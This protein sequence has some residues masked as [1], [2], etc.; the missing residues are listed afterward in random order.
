[1][2]ID[3]Q[4]VVRE[5]ME[6]VRFP[7]TSGNERLLAD[8]LMERLRELG[9]EVT[10]DDAGR[11]LGWGTG[12]V[13]AHW[14]ATVPGKKTLLFCA[15]MD[16]VSPGEHIE[17]YI[18]EEVIYAKGSTVLGADDKAGI[19]PIMEALRVLQEQKLPHVGLEILFTVG[20][21]NGL[22][23]V[24]NLD[25]ALL[26]ADM[27][28]VLDSDGSAGKI[29]VQA[30]SQHKI[31]AV[32][33]GKAAHAGMAPEAGINAIQ[34]A[35]AAV[36]QMKSG[37]IDAETTANI[38]VFQGGKATNIVPEYVEVFCEARSLNADKLA[39]QTRHMQETFEQVASSWG[40]RAEVTVENQYETFKLDESSGVVQLALKAA[41][42]IGAVP[43]LESTGGGSDANFLNRYGIPT[44]VLGVGMQNVHTTD[45]FLYIKDLLRSTE[46]VL[47][48]I[49]AAAE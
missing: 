35:G 47:A 17:P 45:E 28:Y 40:A 44:A 5:F 1:V 31:K 4:R 22:N 8:H 46:Y 43:S 6:M 42:K 21:E 19:V 7:S 12:N 15:H 38:G 10:E 14:P 48:I 34:A 20:E 33:H 39:A 13:I 11:K 32:V 16:H 30:P 2:V 41:Q 25:P 26:K 27:G 29:V 3:K 23:G 24:K 9:L 37:R 18:Q 49:Q 36:A